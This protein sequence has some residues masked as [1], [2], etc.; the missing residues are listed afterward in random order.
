[1]SIFY[2]IDSV[3]CN[4]EVCNSGGDWKEEKLSIYLQGWDYTHDKNPMVNIH[5][6][7]DGKHADLIVPWETLVI[8]IDRFKEILKEKQQT[9][10]S[11]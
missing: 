4:V 10:M 8:I 11:T 6:V 3:D 7:R 1:M 9:R 2:T 5:V